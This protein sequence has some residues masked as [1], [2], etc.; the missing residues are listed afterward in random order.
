[1]ISPNIPI[2]V[3]DIT[4]SARESPPCF[5][6]YICHNVPFKKKVWWRQQIEALGE[7]MNSLT[8]LIMQE[9]EKQSK[10]DRPRSAPGG[11]MRGLCCFLT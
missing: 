8:I 11:M 7:K 5:V 3:P 4:A 9:V 2:H 1:M 10:K 6:L